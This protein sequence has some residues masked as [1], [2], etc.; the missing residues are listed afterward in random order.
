MTAR[1]RRFEEI[2]RAEEEVG[3]YT[4]E[5][6]VRWTP[7]NRAKALRALAHVA[8]DVLVDARGRSE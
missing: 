3:V 2:Q 5:I 6:R 1:E 7:G 4:A 8:I